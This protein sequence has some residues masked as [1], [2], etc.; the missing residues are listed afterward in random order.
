MRTIGPPLQRG[1]FR[2]APQIVDHVSTPIV[3]KEVLSTLSLHVLAPQPVANMIMLAQDAIEE[4]CLHP[5][6]DLK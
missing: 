5:F 1:Q 3:E 2:H 4:L 6:K